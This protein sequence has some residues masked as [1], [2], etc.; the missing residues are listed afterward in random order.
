[1]SIALPKQKH[2]RGP[3]LDYLRIAEDNG[4]LF[5]W[6]KACEI[7]REIFS[8]DFSDNA[9]PLIVI[10]KDG[11]SEVFNTRADVIS[12]CRIG[13]ETLRKCLETG[14]QDRLGRCYDY[15]ILE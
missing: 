3:L 9:K 1:M 12:A 13:N 10:Y 14:K 11:S 6:R 4:D 8:G 2:L 5:A 7:G 15:A